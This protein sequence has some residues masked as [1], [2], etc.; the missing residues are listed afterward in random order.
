M[1]IWKVRLLPSDQSAYMPFHGMETALLK[2]QYD[3]SLN[4]DDQKVALLFMFDL[5][6]A[7][8]TVD[9]SILLETLDSGWCWW[10]S[11]EM[12]HIISFSKK[13]TS[14]NWR[15]SF[16]KETADHWNTTWI[17]HCL[18]AVH[19]LCCWPVSEH[20]KAPPRSPRLCRWPP[21]L[22]V[23]QTHSLHEQKSGAGWFPTR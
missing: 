4:M 3:I 6:I 10:N 5:S 23:I 21:S 8:D 17:L 1:T 11:F 14:T 15:N 13:S 2:V 9:Q 22:P 20:R 19:H 18:C 16:R 12:V 7:F